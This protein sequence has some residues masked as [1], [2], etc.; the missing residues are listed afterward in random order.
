MPDCY[1][2]SFLW[3]LVLV[4]EDNTVSIQVL[5]AKTETDLDSRLEMLSLEKAMKC[6]V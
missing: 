6:L 2:R 3:A 4:T 5:W 1:S